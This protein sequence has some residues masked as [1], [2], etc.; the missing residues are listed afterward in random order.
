MSIP[1]QAALTYL[2]TILPQDGW[3]VQKDNVALMKLYRRN[4][5][6]SDDSFLDIHYDWEQNLVVGVV[7]VDGQTCQ[8]LID[9]TGKPVSGIRS[10]SVSNYDPTSSM[11]VRFEQARKI[12]TIAASASTS[13]A[14][15]TKPSSSNNPTTDEK[16]SPQQNVDIVKFALMAWAI[17]IGVK[18]LK[19]LARA[20][21]WKVL[22]LSLN[23]LIYVFA[24]QTRPSTGSF[25]S[26]EELKRVLRRRRL[27][28][29]PKGFFKGLAGLAARV[30]ASFTAEVPEYKLDFINAGV[31]LLADVK[32]PSAQ[33][34]YY[35]VGAFG[36]WYYVYQTDY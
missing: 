5:A 29:D 23:S 30:S 27:P 35:W 20:A 1:S 36:K 6:L 26:D 2:R 3:S 24:L 28:E 10:C 18:V 22:Y 32:V 19:M 21:D 9:E 13:A 25:D 34:E 8:V 17:A 31:A 16:L 14:P 4:V 7:T 12:A 33:K 15:S 11:D